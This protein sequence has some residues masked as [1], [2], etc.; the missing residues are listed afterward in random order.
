MAA[1]VRAAVLGNYSEVARRAGLDPHRRLRAAGID[2]AYV[3]DPD[4]PVP[5]AALAALLEESARRSGCPT[6]ALEMAQSWR[7]SDLGVVSLLL[8]HERT[9]RAVLAGAERYRHLLNDALAVEIEGASAFVLVRTEFSG[10][11][12][13]RSR[14]ANELALGV[15]LRLF[16][17]I[18]GPGW[19]P[20]AVRVAH[21]APARTQVH[22]RF[23]GAPVHF[24][25]EVNGI[26]CRA[27]D[28]DRPN[29]SRD[30]GLARH[31]RRLLDAMPEASH[32]EAAAIQDVLRAIHVGLPIGKASVERVARGM[33]VTPRSLQRRL[34][35]AGTTFSKLL[36]QARLD[37][38]PR[39]L[40]NPAYSLIQVADLLG[41]DFPS[42]FTRWFRR[43]F[44]RSPARWRREH[45]AVS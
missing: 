5:T 32:G 44:G 43:E 7:M 37:V 11:P 26:V 33:G 1:F 6:I 25:Q 13:A 15:M 17:A 12:A 18:L 23:F 21:P 42:S 45:A 29:P 20:V 35:G 34:V 22:R 38:V 28:L 19:T 9:L 27:E 36:N 4:L 39:Y 2:P 40:A 24:S 10:G 8:A 41:Y 14:Q 16:R 31:A 3:T 30:A